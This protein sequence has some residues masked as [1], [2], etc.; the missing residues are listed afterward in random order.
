MIYDYVFMSLLRTKTQSLAVN[1]WCSLSITKTTTNE[2]QKN[3]NERKRAKG[4]ETWFHLLLPCQVYTFFE[5]SL[6]CVAKMTGVM[7]N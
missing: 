7:G 1:C 5:N 4:R 2:A 3:R 6:Y